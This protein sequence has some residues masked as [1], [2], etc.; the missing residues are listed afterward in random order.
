MIRLP[1]VAGSFYPADKNHLRDQ[2]KNFLSKARKEPGTP[3][4]IIL[5]HAGYEYS[6]QTAGWG[7]K[8]LTRYKSAPG[9]KIILLGCSH[10]AFFTGAAVYD[11][12]SWQTP[13]GKVEID[14][15]LTQKLIKSSQFIKSNL[16]THSQEHSLE[17]QLP[18]LQVI[19]KDFKIIPILLGQTNH[20]MLKNL[21]QAIADNFNENI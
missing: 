15:K 14:E 13:L 6:G 19:L 16:E 5:P 1:V 7:Y 18:F 3:K 2:I 12:D 11:Q 8:Q 20:Q 21:A 4:I 10:R 17:V 9:L